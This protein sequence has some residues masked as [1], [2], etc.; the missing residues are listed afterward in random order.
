[1]PKKPSFL[2]RLTGGVSL[3]EDD[4]DDTETHVTLSSDD[5]DEKRSSDWM[6]EDNEEGH[7]TVDVFQL[8]DEIVLKTMVA[9]VKPDDLQ[10][11][12]TRE[13]VTIRGRRQEEHSISTD[14]YF[15]QELYWGGFSRTILLPQ[16]VDPEEAEAVEKHGLLTIRLPKID[17]KKSQNIKVKS[18]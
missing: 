7:L 15:Y 10:V 9:G 6:E 8:P 11:S 14:D 17:K 16:E 2:E 4:F 5:D 18:G 12:I 1:M 3:D 13:M